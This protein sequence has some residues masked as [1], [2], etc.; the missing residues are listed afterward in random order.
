MGTRQI[1]PESTNLS[2]IEP[3]PAIQNIGVG[4]AP[5][6]LPA[7]RLVLIIPYYDRLR[8]IEAVKV[9]ERNI[10]ASFIAMLGLVLFNFG[11]TALVDSPSI[12]LAAAA[13]LALLKKIPLPYIL[14]PGGHPL[15]PHLRPL[16]VIFPLI[17]LKL[18][19][20]K[21]SNVRGFPVVELSGPT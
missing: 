17:P 1:S 14:L 6:P 20:K 7:N 11:R 10:L 4:T 5:H 16:E 18:L 8:E 21:I 15:H 19:K 13:F 3:I 12:V 2:R 9:V